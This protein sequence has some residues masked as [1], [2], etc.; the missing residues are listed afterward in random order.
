MMRRG[1]ATLV[2]ALALGACTSQG[3]NPIVVEAVNTVNPWGK[4]KAAP[5]GKPVSRADIDKADIAAI[6]A[7][8][9]AQKASPTLL[10]AASNNGGYITYA[11]SLR[12]TLT[13]RGSQVTA[14]RGLGWDLLS[15]KSSQPDP[16]MQPMPI[17]R[18]PRQVTRSYEF[19]RDHPEGR[20]E[21]F[22]CRFSFGD[23]RQITILQQPHRV[24]EVI[25]TCTGKDGTF[26][27]QHFADSV[28]GFVWQSW[29][30]LGPK[31][32]VLEMSVVLPYTG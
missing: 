20:N 8:L 22:D 31:Q 32:G 17:A 3:F 6:Q 25:E 30:W 23:E 5:A 29:Q 9:V 28:T 13:L 21:V 26:Q 2:L 27:N 1:L 10:F 14:S 19:P 11:S 12:Q 7:R 4:P 16:I 24:V 18:W 15:A